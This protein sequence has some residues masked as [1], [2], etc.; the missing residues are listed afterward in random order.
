MW[1]WPSVGAR[2]YLNG[3][4]TKPCNCN[5]EKR[6]IPVHKKINNLHG[7]KNASGII[8]GIIVSSNKP[9]VK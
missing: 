5:A 8:H 6:F 3:H 9:S 2:G 7:K 4:L 1:K